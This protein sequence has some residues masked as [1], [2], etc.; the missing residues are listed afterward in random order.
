MEDFNYLE[1]KLLEPISVDWCTFDTHD[2]GCSGYEYLHGQDWGDFLAFCDNCDCHILGFTTYQKWGQ[3]IL[4]IV[5]ESD[6]GSEISWYHISREIWVALYL[7]FVNPVASLVEADNL[8]CELYKLADRS[9]Y[10]SYTYL[11]SVNKYRT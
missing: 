2:L 8:C 10:E 11:R 1:D 6:D 9:D 4:T 5:F 3:A 7:R